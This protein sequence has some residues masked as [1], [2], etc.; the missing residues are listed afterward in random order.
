MAS[1][2]S[3][4]DE[5]VQGLFKSGQSLMQAFAGFP[6]A[7][8]VPGGNADAPR[9]SLPEAQVHYWQQQ[10]ALWAGVLANA[11]GQ[12]HEPVVAAERGDRRFHAEE[13]RAN[14]WYS[15]L[16]QSYLLNARLLPTRPRSKSAAMWP[17]PKV[18]WCSRTRCSS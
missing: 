9:A 7:D 18:R 12:A 16:K 10:M 13:W 4:P 17:C 2:F 5:F 14:P 11:T 6:S 1:P 3:V 8:Q 15:V